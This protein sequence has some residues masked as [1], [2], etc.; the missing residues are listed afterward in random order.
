M[1]QKRF[2]HRQWLD[3]RELLDNGKPFAYVDTGMQSSIICRKLNKLDYENEQLKSKLEI[4]EKVL[5]NVGY[6]LVYSETEERW[7]VE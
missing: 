6:D 5:N 7:I 2:T 4:A 3:E 1:T